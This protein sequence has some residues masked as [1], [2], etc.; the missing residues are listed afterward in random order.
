MLLALA[1]R[2][3]S[4]RS[5]RA[6]LDSTSGENEERRRHASG[7]KKETTAWEGRKKKLAEARV[8]C[9]S[10]AETKVNKELVRSLLLSMP[11]SRPCTDHHRAA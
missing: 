2:S 7:V 1:E 10:A 3:L 5:I 4:A 9:K 6:D 11:L 8:R